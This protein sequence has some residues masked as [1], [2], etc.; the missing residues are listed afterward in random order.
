AIYLRAAGYSV[1]VYEANGRVGGRANRIE[2]DGFRF[3]TGPSLLNYPWVFEELFHAAGARL[4]DYVELLPVEPGVAF[5]W[6]DGTRFALSSDLAV[7]AASLEPVERDVAPGLM[8]FLSDA[9]AKYDLAFAKL[10]GR[11]VDNPLVWFA[12]LRLRELKRLSVWRSLYGE[13]GRFF[14]SRHIREA[15]GSYGMYL[16]GSPF[17]LPGVFSILPYG[18]LA[19]GLWLPR[20]G[21]YGLV[22]GVERLARDLGVEI[23][24]GARIERIETG[25]GAVKG[26][27][28][29]GG[30]V[31]AFPLVVS[32]V[33]VPVTDAQLLGHERLLDRRRRKNARMRMTPGVVTF[34]WGVRG[35]V[36][37]LGHHTIFLPEAYRDAFRDLI[38]GT[39][40]P[41]GLP[42]YVSVAS[43]TDPTLA[44]AG[45]TT[46]FV[47]VPVPL[48]HRMGD[49]DWEQ[50]TAEIKARVLERLE[51]HGCDLTADRIAVEHVYTPRDWR[52][53]F[54]LHEG[55]GFGAAHTLF[56]VGPFRARN[57]ARE[58]RGMYYT[59]ASTT[60]GT[61]M[62]MVILSGKLTAERILAREG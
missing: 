20:G 30:G 22:E 55:S 4:E 21:I 51:R 56:Q 14:R 31:D 23:L 13:L 11:N 18:E 50:V 5:Q 45:A 59:G 44:P 53:R 12:S 3:D 62:P 16:G 58:L 54:G 46:V 28:R 33:D 39:G 36:R 38:R 37:G 9:G 27:R 42:F 60:P 35:S 41:R 26:V 25:G 1:R 19:Y 2:T 7:L 8:R 34:Y 17:E 49:V 52:D 29:A 57:Y 32:N 6:P 40:V 10:V 47:L 15:F 48:L 24:T 43:A 61:G